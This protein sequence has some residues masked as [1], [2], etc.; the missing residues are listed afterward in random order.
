MTK[1]SWGRYS[2]PGTTISRDVNPLQTTSYIFTWNDG[3]ADRLF[4]PAELASFVN[5]T[6]G[7]VNGIASEIRHPYTDNMDVWVERRFASSLSGRLGYVYKKS[8]NNWGVD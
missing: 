3:N 2:D 4:Q 8:N 1:A 5:S 6:G 7:V